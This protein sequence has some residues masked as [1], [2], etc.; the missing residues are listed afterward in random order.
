[1][2]H[3]SCDRCQRLID[4]ENEIRYVVSVEIQAAIEPGQEM[5]TNY[6]QL[7]ELEKALH[8]MAD[9]SVDGKLISELADQKFH[10]II[11][12]ATQNKMLSATIGNLWHIRD[13]APS[14]HKAYQ[15]IC[16]TDGRARVKEHQEIF[17]ALKSRDADAA[18]KAMHAHFS[19]L[20]NKLIAAD[21]S[22][23]IEEARQRA[24]ESRERFSL[25]HLVSGA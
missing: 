2:I 1:M 15:S 8:E 4:G 7:E 23:R 18:R 3:H 22:E 6:E 13:H 12:E 21:E 25:N 9:E 16:D 24:L 5:T 19:R 10:Q 17:N 11:S 20:L 14:I